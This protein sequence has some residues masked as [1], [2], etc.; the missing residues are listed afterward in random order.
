CAVLVAGFALGGQQ[1][2]NWL[3]NGSA[4]LAKMGYT[5][6]AIQIWLSPI[7][8][9]LSIHGSALRSEGRI[10]FMAISS[11]LVSLANIIFTYVL[12][13]VFHRGVAGSAEGTVLAQ[14]AALATVI[15]YR[16]LGRSRLGMGWQASPGGG[17][18]RD[19]HRFLALGAPQSLSFVGISLG[20]TAIIFA[21]QIWN[22]D[23][24]ASTVAAYG[25]ALRILT[26]AFLPL[27]GL[28]MAMQT[29]VGNNYGASLWHRSDGGLKLA[30]LIALVYGASVQLF[31]L[32]FR[33]RAG[34]VFVDDPA[35]AGEVARILPIMTAMYFA[36][37][38]VMM[39]SAYF[40]ATGEASRSAII[41]LS[42]TYVFAIPFTFLLPFVFG[43]SGIWYAGPAAELAMILL[44]VVVLA[45]AQLVTGRRWGVFR[46]GAQA[47]TAGH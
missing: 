3:A 15:V 39:L 26:F 19:W 22:P 8:F 46:H 24:Y 1:I 30:A 21:L 31:V 9:A 40:Q 36:A 33:H 25:I 34:L 37:G 14:F 7:N 6:I 4:P 2:V 38:P 17:W 43:E 27:L 11:L 32:A 16:G 29:L 28:S 47:E 44:S 23:N 20:S 41:S 13:A 5:Y 35:S 10:G 12:I 42:R 45:Q 18:R